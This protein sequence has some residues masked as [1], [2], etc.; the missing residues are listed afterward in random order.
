V[1]RVYEAIY[2]RVLVP[3]SAACAN[4]SPIDGNAVSTC[5][6]LLAGFAAWQTVATARL[7]TGV[8]PAHLHS[9]HRIVVDAPIDRCFMYSTP[10]GEELWVDGWRPRYLHP[11]DGSTQAGMVF[12]TGDGDELTIWTLVDFDRER[13]RSRYVRCTPAT[14]TGLVEIVCRAVDASRTE[15][16]VSYML[17][18]LNVHGRETIAA[19][20]GGRFI[21]MI[22]GWSRDIAAR[23]DLLLAATI[24]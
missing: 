10:A 5:A 2:A 8:M 7:S 4:V 24:R 19:Y 23:R 17:T 15:V 1:K 13:H 6:R 22:E 18:A 11:Q 12:T 20:E 14:H 16:S 9:T 21:A 3:W